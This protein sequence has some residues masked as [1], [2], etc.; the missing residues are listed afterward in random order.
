LYVLQGIDGDRQLLAPERDGM[1]RY[2]VPPRYLFSDRCAAER[3]AMV[4]IAERRKCW[5]GW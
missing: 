3:A 1:V 5:S 4:R 2:L